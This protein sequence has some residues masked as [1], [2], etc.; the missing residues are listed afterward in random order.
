MSRAAGTC[1]ACACTDLEACEGGCSWVDESHTFCSACRDE[2]E[3]L[4][5]K[6]GDAHARSVIELA[7]KPVRSGGRTWYDTKTVHEEDRQDVADALRFLQL[8]G[9]QL[10]RY[11]VRRN[12]PFVGLVQFLDQPW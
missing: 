3:A 12:R 10:Q 6:L 8:R 2:A 11:E 9:D 1:R 5:F 7:C 4:A